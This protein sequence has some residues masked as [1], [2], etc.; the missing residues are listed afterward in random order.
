MGA[1]PAM[2]GKMSQPVP[3]SVVA[4]QNKGVVRTLG[5]VRDGLV[6]PQAAGHV[7]LGVQPELVAQL[8][9]TGNGPSS[10]MFNAA[11][12][13]TLQEVGSIQIQ[14]AIH[15]TQMLRR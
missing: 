7:A 2:Y 3:A 12:P 9:L 6:Q 5:R 1:D 15:H 10:Q 11:G 4:M 13:E 14:F 8:Q